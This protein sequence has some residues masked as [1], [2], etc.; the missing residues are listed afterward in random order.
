MT[1]PPCGR[2]HWTYFTGARLS[3]SV[4]TATR[5]AQPG[6]VLLMGGPLVSVTGQ[7]TEAVT[8]GLLLTHTG[9]QGITNESL[10]TVEC[11]GP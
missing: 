3:A 4:T 1:P 10:E 9:L 6:W 7:R 8:C 11:R 2:C 5:E